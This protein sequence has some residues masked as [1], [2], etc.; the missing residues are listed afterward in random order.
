MRVA[1]FRQGFG[2]EKPAGFGGMETQQAETIRELQK[3]GVNVVFDWQ[4]ANI[5]HVFGIYFHTPTHIKTFKSMGK[6]VVVSTI[7]WDWSEMGHRP[8]VVT[9]ANN[10]FQQC[11]QD[12]DLLLPNSHA[13]ARL[14]HEKFGQPMEKMRVVV[15]AVPGDIRERAQKAALKD[16]DLCDLK[17]Y[18]LIVGRI[19]GRKNQARFL[20]AMRTIPVPI[21]MIGDCYE[22]QYFWS[23]YEMAKVRQ[24][25]S[26]FFI[27]IPPPEIYAYMQ[28]ALLVAQPSIYETP[29]L[30]MLEAAALGVPIAPTNRGSALEYFGPGVPYL[31]P[32]SDDSMR[33]CL[34][35]RGMDMAELQKKVLEQYTWA[36]AAKQTVQAYKEFFPEEAR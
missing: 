35:A 23:C 27:G 13:E 8:N 19:E 33:G 7:Y 15:N 34:R 36:H 29:G 20:Y 24:A 17:D 11:F 16:G 4:Q 25:R 14:V 32:F 21:L 12:A 26:E 18:I 22:P 31:D 9:W 10:R 2:A 28:N 6:K 1:F 5:V 30:V 3:L